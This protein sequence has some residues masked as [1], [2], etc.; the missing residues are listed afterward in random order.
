MYY[1]LSKH[2]IYYIRMV[3]FPDTNLTIHNVS[4]VFV[5][6]L[7]TFQPDSLQGSTIFRW[8]TFLYVY[9]TVVYLGWLFTIYFCT[10]YFE[11]I[12]Y[13]IPYLF[14][15]A[16][17]IYPVP[18]FAKENDNRGIGLWWC[19]MGNINLVWMKVAYI[20][21]DNKFSYK[22]NAVLSLLV[23]D[24]SHVNHPRSFQVFC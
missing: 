4:F 20:G 19:T 18:F 24:S 12:R 14:T 3:I 2:F 9:I 11:L 5:F 6:L 7:F 10:D 23:W 1:K 8:K 15:S 16:V 17:K 22:F 13:D 21:H